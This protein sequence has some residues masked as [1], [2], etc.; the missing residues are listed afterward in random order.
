M[1]E[2]VDGQ[3]HKIIRV[4][5]TSDTSWEE[6]A[7]TGVAEA[8]KTINDLRSATVVESDMLV[9]DGAVVY[10]VKL[11]MGFQLDRSR[12]ADDGFASVQ[13][14]RYLILAN[15]TLPSPGLHELVNEKAA[16]GQSEFHVLVPEAQKYNVYPDPTTPLDSHVVE[17]AD[18][19]RLLSLQE[20]EERLDAFRT[21]F[22]NLGPALT[23]E[24]GI[25]DP[26]S[27]T[28]RVMDRSTFDEIIVSTLP[29]GISRWLRLDLPTR[30]ERAFHLPVT[31]LV[32]E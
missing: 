32:Q 18:H 14:R 29:S 6:A 23:G 7:R 13:V 20:A 22:A 5:S 3:V 15:Q 8:V 1:P 26:V 9:R 2:V 16:T 21:T 24:V 25:G 10:R 4:V 12:L 30:L 11:E 17:V 28:R 31:H 19:E 27:A